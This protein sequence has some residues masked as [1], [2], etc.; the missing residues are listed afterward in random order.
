M[1]S[2]RSRGSK[3][4]AL[5]IAVL[6]MIVGLLLQAPG[7]QASTPRGTGGARA[8]QRRVRVGAVHDLVVAGERS[9][10]DQRLQL[11]GQPDL[12]VRDDRPT[13]FD[14]QPDH[15][16]H[17]ERA[18]QR[19]LFLACTGGEQRRPRCLVSRTKSSRHRRRPHL[20]RHADAEPAARRHDQVPSVRDDQVHLDRGAG[21]CDLHLRGGQLQP[22]AVP[23]TD[24][25]HPSGQHRRNVDLDHDR[26]LLQ[27]LR[28]GQLSGSGVRGQRGR[29]PRACRR[30]RSRSASSTTTPC[31]RRR[32]RSRRWAASPSPTR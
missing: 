23:G 28:A 7:A 4:A 18:G 6:A 24:D 1:R 21:R 16:G 12:D 10:R 25:P 31:R 2:S 15:P 30:R 22:A 17:G 20:A 3:M 29:H 13:R 9:D 27:R 5:I 26:R 32:C 19:H 14:H 8:G 11:A